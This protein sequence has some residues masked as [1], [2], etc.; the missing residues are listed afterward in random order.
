LFGNCSNVCTNS[1]PKKTQFKTNVQST[2]KLLEHPLEKE[3]VKRVAPFVM[4]FLNNK[5]RDRLSWANNK[6]KGNQKGNK[7][8]D[9]I[10]KHIKKTL[11]DFLTPFNNRATY[12][13]E[14]PEVQAKLFKLLRHYFI[15]KVT[16]CLQP[17]S[18]IHKMLYLIRLTFM[19][20]EVSGKRFLR[21]LIRRWRFC[22]FMRKL[23]RKKM[24]SMYKNMHLNLLNMTKE[25]FGDGEGEGNGGGMMSEFEL[26]GN[27]LGMFTNEDVSVYD[28]MKKKFYKQVTRKYMFEPI[29]VNEE[30]SHFDENASPEYYYDEGI[31]DGTQGRYKQDTNRSAISKDQGGKTPDRDRDKNKKTPDREKGKKK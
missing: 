4:N 9:L 20:R 7:F 31:G 13:K 26:L 10:K 1:N 25:V 24:E 29:E 6:L 18:K 3:P 19:H 12:N 27:S 11:P 30:E 17:V 8:Y 22:S 2:R 5:M 15:R 16:D 28:E 14:T 23:A 21:E